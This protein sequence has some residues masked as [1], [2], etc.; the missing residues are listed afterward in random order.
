MLF[1]SGTGGFGTGSG[2]GKVS[3]QDIVITKRVEKSSP[4]LALHCAN[5]KHIA[6][7]LITARKAGEKPLE[8]LKIKLTQVLVSSYQ[9]GASHGDDI[10]QESITLNFATILKTYTPQAPDGTAQGAVEQGWD[11]KANKK[12]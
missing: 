5:G 11:L 9:L 10:P 6:T 12:L 1:R 8:F 4:V 3:F 7:G 2:A